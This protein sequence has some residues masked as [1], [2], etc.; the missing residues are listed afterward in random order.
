MATQGKDPDKAIVI[1]G[2]DGEYYKIE[3][4]VWKDAKY[5]LPDGG[6]RG[7]VEQ[8]EM[9]GTLVAFVSQDVTGVGVGYA[10]TVVNVK[11]ILK[12]VAKGP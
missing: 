2:D 3:E 1:I 5:R 6:G 7:I 4:G 11:A 9:F 8:L 12:S 10:C